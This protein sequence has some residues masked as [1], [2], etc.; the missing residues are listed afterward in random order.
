MSVALDATMVSFVV[1]KKLE[2]QAKASEQP[3]HQNKTVQLGHPGGAAFP[4]P[5]HHWYRKKVPSGKDSLYPPEPYLQHACQCHPVF[6][7]PTEKKS[8]EPETMIRGWLIAGLELVLT[9]RPEPHL[10]PRW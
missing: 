6:P 3:L 5:L 2:E 8:P 7:R 9:V 1:D 10:A 4:P